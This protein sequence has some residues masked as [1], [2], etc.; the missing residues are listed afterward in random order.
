VTVLAKADH[1]IGR[2]VGYFLTFQH[3]PNCSKRRNDG[4]LRKSDDRN[5]SVIISS[6]KRE[7]T[8]RRQ[9]LSLSTYLGHRVISKFSESIESPF[10]DPQDDEREEKSE[11]QIS[12]RVRRKWIMNCGSASPQ[13]TG[14]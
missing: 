2:I 14:S 9:Y 12:I 5:V 13:R 10:K 4:S 1:P 7:I 8:C 11:M 6:G 3:E